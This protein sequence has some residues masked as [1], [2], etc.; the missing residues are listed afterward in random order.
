MTAQSTLDNR[1]IVNYRS[2]SYTHSSF[3]FCFTN[4]H[5]YYSLPYSAL[6]SVKSSPNEYKRSRTNISEYQIKSYLTRFYNKLLYK[7]FV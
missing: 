1:M 4:L 5:I 6:I 7:Q 3:T 2:S